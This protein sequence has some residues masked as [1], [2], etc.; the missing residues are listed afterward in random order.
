MFSVVGAERTRLEAIIRKEHEDCG[1]PHFVNDKTTRLT[2]SSLTARTLRGIA[3]DPD[4][5]LHSVLAYID[6]A[7]TANGTGGDVYLAELCNRDGSGTKDIVGVSVWFGPGK[8]P[9]DT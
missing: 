3:Y 5:F 6:C 1:R 9:D 8:T 2:T 7:L 4:L